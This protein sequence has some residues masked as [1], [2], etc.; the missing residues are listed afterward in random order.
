MQKLI[1]HIGTQKTGTSAIQEVCSENR[2]LLL[3]QGINYSLF[4][5]GPIDTPAHHAHHILSHKWAPG[6]LSG[7]IEAET[8]D[9]V[10]NKFIASLEKHST[11]HTTVISSEH[12][13]KAG[14][15]M[16]Q[17]IQTL[18][19]ELDGKADTTVVVYF[20]RPDTFSLS[21]WA[22][23]IKTQKNFAMSFEDYCKSDGLN[24][25]LS[26]QKN[27]EVWRKAFG[28]ENVVPKIFNKRYFKDGDIV[29]D[30]LSI[31]GG[32]VTSEF[33]DVGSV[34]V[35]LSPF[36]LNA[37][38]CLDRSNIQNLGKFID[39]IDSFV[40]DNFTKDDQKL[41]DPLT[42][43][44]ASDI[45]KQ[46]GPAYMDL[47]RE[48]LGEAEVLESLDPTLRNGTFEPV[49]EKWKAL[50][51]DVWQAGNQAGRSPNVQ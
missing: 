9:Q 34:N 49:P 8:T 38:S 33:R 23:G 22:H 41:S 26:Y 25:L 14:V 2:D 47:A 46:H 12:F 19:D 3:K 1:L 37:L 40:R 5:R 18:S 27:L 36:T 13:Y 15:M 50:L 43:E 42:Q 48:I 39:T 11:C 31:A 35:S 51:V 32:H 44:I 4:G 10:W 28:A 17:A 30:F 24:A 45:L 29:R 21:N 20:R 7:R 16:P 6:W